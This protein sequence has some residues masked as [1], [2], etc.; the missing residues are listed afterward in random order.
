M[1]KKIVIS[2]L[3]VFVVIVLAACGRGGDGETKSVTTE[4]AGSSESSQS[5]NVPDTP[6]YVRIRRTLYQDTGYVNSLITC[7]TMDG[8]ITSSVSSSEVPSQDDQSNFGT[9]C[10]YQLE[11]D[12]TVVVLIGDK[13]E[14]FR[15]VTSDF[16]TMPS[17][18][19]CFIG[20]VNKASGSTFLVTYVKMPEGVFWR[21]PAEGDYSV[22]ARD[23][24]EN[25]KAGDSVIVW[26]TGEITGY[27]PACIDAYRIEKY[28]R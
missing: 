12:D 4:P 2:A 13:Y 15:D 11:G 24:D 7:G 22:T 27:D 19:A 6:L 3:T 20:K 21:P 9:G 28:E 8:Q 5:E 17:G 23:A 10:E 1:M 16:T 25:I 26:H 14:I 18:V